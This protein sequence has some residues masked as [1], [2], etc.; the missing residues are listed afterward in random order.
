[1]KLLK[2]MKNYRKIWEEHYGPIPFDNNDRRCEIHHID[3][4]RENNEISNLMLVTIQEHYDIHYFQGD[5][6]ACYW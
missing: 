3:S 6:A 1:M 5:W 2:K 4:N